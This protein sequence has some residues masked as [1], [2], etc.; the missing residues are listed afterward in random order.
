MFKSLS[1]TE[2]T[3]TIFISIDG[4]VYRVPENITVAAAMLSL[5]KNTFRE[6]TTR[7]MPRGAFC[8]MGCCFDCMMNIDGVTNQQA[9]MVKVKEGMS[10]Q[11]QSGLS[12]VIPTDNAA[13]TGFAKGAANE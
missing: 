11:R 2:N 7:K 10:I 1:N 6:T 3:K 9:C 4:D 5:G 8:M 12:Q 13:K